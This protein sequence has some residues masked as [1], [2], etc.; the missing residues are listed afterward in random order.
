M[1]HDFIQ[2]YTETELCANSF[3][4]L[5]PDVTTHRPDYR[6]RHYETNANPFGGNLL[7]SIVETPEHLEDLFALLLVHSHP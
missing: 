4:R 7:V 6:L 5:E 1:L 3:S 2:H